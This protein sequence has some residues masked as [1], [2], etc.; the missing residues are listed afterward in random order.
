MIRRIDPVARL[1]SRLL[2][3]EKPARY[4]G[5]EY[6]IY[7]KEGTLRTAIVFPDLYELGMSN[8]AF[9]IIYNGLNRMEEISCDRA[10]APAPDFE[11]LLEEEGLPLYGLDTGIALADMDLLLFTLGYELGITGILTVLGS[12]RIA[13]RCSERGAG[14]PIVIMGGPCVSNPLPYSLFV[15]AFWIGEAEAGFFDLA[16]ELLALKKNGASRKDLLDR[17]AAHPH[18]WMP[19]KTSARR[20]V[21]ADFGQEPEETSQGI[22]REILREP[23]VFPISSIRTVHPHG[24]VEIMRG[25]PNGCRFCHAGMWYRPMR[26]KRADIVME[27]VEAFVRKGGYREISLSSLSTGDYCHITG[28][29]AAL[30]DR[31]SGR[32]ISF[33]LPSLRVSG[34]SLPLLA[35]ISEVR[36]SGLTFAV[37]TP[38]A[39]DQLSLNKEVALAEVVSIIGAA[40][41]YGWRGAKF[42]FMIGLPLPGTA[43]G[44][45]RE[46][47][48]I[49]DFILEAGKAA[50]SHFTLNVGTF[51]PKPH[52]PYQRAS[53]LDEEGA[54]KKINY[55]RDRLKPR[56]HKVSAHSPFV[57]L[58]EGIFARGTESSGLLAEAAYRQGCRLDAWSEH[59]QSGIWK[60][61]ISENKTLVEE[62]LRERHTNEKLPWA[63]I[64]SGVGEGYLE[65]ENS[66]S[67]LSKTTPPC[68]ENC[69]HRCGVCG[70]NVGIAANNTDI[71]D[72]S[73]HIP[74]AVSDG[75]SRFPDKESHRMLFSFAKKGTA[76]FVSHL[77]VIEVF[78]AAV[79]RS[80]LPAVYTQGFNPILKVDF[81]APAP[82]GLSCACEIASM[83]LEKS[84][85]PGE[86]IWQI[87]AALPAGFSVNAAE[88][89][90]IPGG[91][92]K[93]SVSSVLWGFRYGENFVPAKEEKQ[94][95]QTVLAA[96]T[97]ADAAR[98]NL[99]G[100]TRDGILAKSPGTGE[101]S[102]EPA[103]KPVDYFELYRSYYKNQQ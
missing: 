26:Q 79:V 72:N 88:L 1:G 32:H 19:G 3:V 4:A 10:F 96:E 46:E 35:S 66:R 21:M 64:Q 55:I 11:K 41:K 49:V 47:E 40:K 86:F 13:L 38:A 94:Y 63:V 36:K 83:D 9:R 69:E 93:H 24:A 71:G 50:A 29:T 20:A 31:Y 5:G 43:P 56:G 85:D 27:E 28:L 76:V 87:N 39:A 100:L 30:N 53:Q 44:N 65:E 75:E 48:G 7:A 37:E 80:G 91:G 99:F 62:S 42:Y 67:E 97:A 92:K 54:W 51:V 70:K 58:L 60:N 102:A 61:I 78:S 23:A 6:G 34:F 74:Q 14:D 57:S 25:C 22:S 81:A 18:I 98:K 16:G 84:L 90:L 59:I 45:Q 15:D 12:S 33:Q 103:G 68:L 101:P 73:V 89:F 8:Q 82:V 17:I 2:E 95:R 77:G 52:T